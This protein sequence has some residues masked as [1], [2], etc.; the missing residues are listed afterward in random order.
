M[1]WNNEHIFSLVSG[2]RGSYYISSLASRFPIMV[3]IANSQ[4][5]NLVWRFDTKWKNL[6]LHH[7]RGCQQALFP[8][9]MDASRWLDH[10]MVSGFFQDKE[11]KRKEDRT[12]KTDYI[13]YFIVSF[14][15]C[16]F[17]TFAT[18]IFFELV[19]SAYAISFF[20]FFIHLFILH[21]GCSL[22]LHLLLPIPLPIPQSPPLPSPQFS[23]HYRER[24]AQGHAACK[25]EKITGVCSWRPCHISIIFN[26]YPVVSILALNVIL[27]LHTCRF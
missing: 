6:L 2:R 21:P 8:C 9:H 3:K 18:V 19:C 25:G 12:W 14:S 15:E 5:C 26:A 27:H 20:L 17:V 7:R 16:H 1:I 13:V 24:I 10:K 4:G 23:T 11:C 22:P